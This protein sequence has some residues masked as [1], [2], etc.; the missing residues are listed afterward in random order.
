MTDLRKLSHLVEQSRRD[1]NLT[2]SARAE[3]QK[4]TER[5]PEDGFEIELLYQHGTDTEEQ[6]KA[7]F[8]L[9]KQGYLRYSFKHLGSDGFAYRIDLRG[10]KFTAG[11]LPMQDSGKREEFATGAVRD[12][13]EGKSRVDL[14]SPFAMERL[15]EWLRQGAE[16]YA[17]RNWEKGIPISRMVASLYRHLLK[18]QQRE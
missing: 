10:E 6:E 8:L 2:E 9:E 5:F 14:I 12:A 11:N 15:G 3:F 1:T 17:S 16:K 7:F 13:A 4:L 18:F